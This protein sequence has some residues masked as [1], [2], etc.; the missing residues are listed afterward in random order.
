MIETASSVNTFSLG[1]SP[2][3]LVAGQSS[4]HVTV[5]KIGAL[6]SN[7]QV[8]FEKVKEVKV[9][10]KNISKVVRTT[11]NDF[12]LGTQSGII[13]CAFRPANSY[14]IQPTAEPE[15]LNGKDITELSEFAQDQYCVG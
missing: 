5:F 1:D 4:G 9:T 10:D 3:I 14:N 13:F 7:N 12:A 6:Q 11:R 15:V 2:E 8:V